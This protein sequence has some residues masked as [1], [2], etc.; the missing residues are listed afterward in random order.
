MKHVQ[1]ALFLMSY[2]GTHHKD[3]T[4]DTENI[5][6]YDISEKLCNSGVS[7]LKDILFASLK[8]IYP[9]ATTEFCCRRP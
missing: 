8:E 3:R 9:E 7:F 1:K 2:L 4:S 6:S 5:K